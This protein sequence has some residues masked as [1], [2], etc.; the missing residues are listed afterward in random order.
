MNPPGN[1]GHLAAA[2]AA[3]SA[4][5]LARALTA[6]ADLTRTGQPATVAALARQAR[7]S[8]S[9]LYAHPELLTD[10]PRPTPDRPTTPAGIPPAA[11]RASEQALRQRL[12][13]AHARNQALTAE[14]TALRDQIAVLYGELRA[15]KLRAPSA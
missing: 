8:R 5:T 6:L 15:L 14:V 1:P 4:D 3:R 9:W 2:A 7:V 10:L 11:E 12:S 13:L